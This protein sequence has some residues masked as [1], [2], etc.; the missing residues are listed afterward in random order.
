MFI[1]NFLKGYDVV[2]HTNIIQKV[3]SHEILISMVPPYLHDTKLLKHT[4]Q[5]IENLKSK[6]SNHVI[7]PW[8]NKLAMVKHIVCT[9]TSS[10]SG[11]H[12]GCNKGFGCWH[13]K[14]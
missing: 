6:L 14:Y 4:Q 2:T 11:E 7:G 10:Q 5:S 9:F 13:E 12:H 3:V 1:A 8:S